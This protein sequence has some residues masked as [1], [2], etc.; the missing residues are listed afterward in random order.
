M[1]KINYRSK[2]LKKTREITLV[3][4]YFGHF[5]YDAST[6]FRFE[7]PKFRV[8]GEK[9]SVFMDFQRLKWSKVKNM[10]E[11]F[12]ISNHENTLLLFHFL[13]LKFQLFCFFF[14]QPTALWEISLFNVVF[15]FPSNFTSYNR[16]NGLCKDNDEAKNFSFLFS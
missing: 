2:T 3:I 11:I 15:F 9:Y 10:S 8:H 12:K 7:R 16:F 14:I 1:H 5:G 4:Y 13:T 6:R